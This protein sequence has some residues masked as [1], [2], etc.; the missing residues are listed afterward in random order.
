MLAAA[1]ARM[2]NGTLYRPAFPCTD[3]QP[4]G[5][6]IDPAT[7]KRFVSESADR[8]A[9]FHAAS[10]VLASNGRRMPL[11]ILDGDAYEL[12][13]N[14]HRMEKNAGAGYVTKH[15]SLEDLAEHYKIPLDALK[16]TI[17]EYNAMAEKGEDTAFKADFA[18][19]KNN[20][21]D[22]P[23]YYAVMV[24]PN[25]TYSLAGAL[26]TPKAEVVS[27]LDDAPIPGL[28]AAGEATSGVHGAMRLGGC[29]ILDCCVF[30]MLA[31]RNVMAKKV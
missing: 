24:K 22:K 26:I 8:V 7:G 11:S 16:A 21:V 23:P 31:G 1:G 4:L 9:I 18:K 20:K 14:K 13:E 10:K 2:I 27:V 6:M 5:M 25:L 15:D 3:E 29:A 19:T 30:G 17:E 28:Y 12:V